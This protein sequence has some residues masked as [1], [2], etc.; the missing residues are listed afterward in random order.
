MLQR[1]DQM[2]NK[3]YTVPEEI[4]L[5]IARLKLRAMGIQ[6]DVLTEEQEHYLASWQEGT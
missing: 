6:I 3:V 1:G 2:E 5:E 4:D